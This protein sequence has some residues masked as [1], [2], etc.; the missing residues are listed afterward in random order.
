MDVHNLSTIP[1]ITPVPPIQWRYT[2]LLDIMLVPDNLLRDRLALI[3]APTSEATTDI[4]PKCAGEK[5]DD[6]DSDDDIPLICR[7]G[8]A[9]Y[10]P[11]TT[12]LD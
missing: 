5:I 11:P 9:P 2:S 8:A 1:P 7:E 3:L 4:V 12:S 10:K 6:L